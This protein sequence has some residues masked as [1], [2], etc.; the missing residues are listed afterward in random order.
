MYKPFTEEL[1]NQPIDK[2]TQQDL[3]RYFQEERD[4]TLF[5]E[6]KSFTD[7]TEDTRSRSKKEAD[8]IKGVLKTIDAFLNSSG[9]LLIW[10]APEPVDVERGERKVKMCRGPLAPV[11]TF[12]DRDSFINQLASQ[13][14]PLP[15][16]VRIQSVP[17]S[18]GYVYLFEVPESQNKP[19][20]FDGRYYVRMDTRTDVA[21][22]Y[23]VYALCRQVK[24]PELSMTAKF[25]R[26]LTRLNPSTIDFD[27]SVEITNQTET[28]NDYDIYLKV[29]VLNGTVERIRLL[30]G[31]DILMLDNVAK[32]LPSGLPAR[33]HFN[34]KINIPFNDKTGDI[35]KIW[36][37]GKTSQVKQHVYSVNFVNQRIQGVEH[38]IIYDVRAKRL[39]L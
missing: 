10:G 21:P 12:Y 9:G 11:P 30:D 13:I 19:H 36:Y 35:I 14:S 17:V 3:E 34:V 22:H 16:E 6:F 4:E 28:T 20:Q 29:Q 18:G 24:V 32:I 25:D 31:I 2:I 39:D 27:V 23:L 38:S 8:R 37:G 33:A 1:F 15:Q 5:L 26:A 7:K